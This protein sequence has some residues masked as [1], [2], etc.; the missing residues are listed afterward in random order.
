M[1][2]WLRFAKKYIHKIDKFVTTLAFDMASIVKLVSVTLCDFFK[3]R[4]VNQQWIYWSE[5]EADGYMGVEIDQNWLL[6]TLIRPEKY[7]AGQAKFAASI[8]TTK[9]MLS[10]ALQASQDE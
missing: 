3:V 5:E 2:I 7:S 6:Q 1:L 10:I 4:T 9:W 8:K